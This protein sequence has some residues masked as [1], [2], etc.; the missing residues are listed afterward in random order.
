M[1]FNFSDTTR[2]ERLAQVSSFR[3]LLPEMLKNF[4]LQ[5]PFTVAS[6][7]RAWPDFVGSSIAANSNPLALDNDILFVRTKHS[8]FANEISMMKTIIISKLNDKFKV[9][10]KDIKILR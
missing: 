4:D 3:D 7:Q 10:I 2:R 6:I 5:Q 8:V 9:S 1:I